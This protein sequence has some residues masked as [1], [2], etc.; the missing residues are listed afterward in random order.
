MSEGRI[1]ERRQMLRNAVAAYGFRVLL[2]LN[3][4]LLTPYLFRTLGTAGFGTWSVMFTLMMLSELVE[5]GFSTGVIKLVSEFHGRG[6]RAELEATVRFGVFLMGALGILFALGFAAT[7]KWLGVL[8]A[9]V[10][11]T[12]FRN[13][14]LV[15]ALAV[16]VRYPCMSLQAALMGYQRF[17]LSNLVDAVYVVVFTAGAVAGV[18]AGLGVFGVALGYA[19]GMVSSAILALVLLARI[20]SDLKVWPQ[21]APSGTRR[22]MIDTSSFAFLAESMIF[23]GQRMDVVVI[24]AIRSAAASAPFAA[25]LKLQSAVQ[26]LTL[27]FVRLLMP[28]S[29]ELWAQGQRAEVVRRVT[30][31]TRVALQL[32]LPFAVAIALFSHDIVRL[33]LGSAAPA[34]TSTIVVVLMVVQISTLAAAP[35][36]TVLIGVGRVRW[37]GLL[38]LF[39]GLANIGLTVILVMKYGVVGAAIATL[40]TS[41]VLAPVKYPL[42]CRSLGCPTMRFVRESLGMAT[43]SS[44]PALAAMAVVWAILPPGT[45][46]F[47]LGSAVGCG[48]AAAVGVAQVGVRRLR[49]ILRRE[50][51]TA[52][53]TRAQGA[54]VGSDAPVG[55]G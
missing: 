4:L 34:V 50:S 8:A 53:P 39:E 48:I 20:D 32:T 5:S 14:M 55:M 15:L 13:G 2:G 17:D 24:A 26:A 41:A 33:W 54:S 16:I 28:M 38:A 44:L 9:G 1:D 10:D 30:V 18:E 43:L 27:P 22:R 46:R 7:G 6:Q 31:A 23:V 47:L 29:S 37:V 35:A 52:D 11:R 25:A 42:V 21:L 49:L 12:D 40:L 36:E 19:A 3:A 45:L 51:R